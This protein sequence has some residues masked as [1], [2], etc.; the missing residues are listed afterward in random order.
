MRKVDLS[1]DDHI[2]A[3]PDEIGRTMSE[4]D[5]LISDIFEGRSR[6]V[7]E[8]VF[9]GGTDQ[10]I[11]GYGDLVQPRPRGEDVEWF[12]V[13]LARQKQHFSIY[14]NAV[15]DGQYLLRQYEGKLGKV[16]LGSASI[17]FGHMADVDR[18][19]LSDLLTRAAE[20]TRE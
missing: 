12:A 5:T 3:F 10:H 7:W 11:I 16:R 1:P 4:L 8:G 20:L 9:W 14:V 6:T 17:A 18:E 15:D 2:A 13:G 19:A